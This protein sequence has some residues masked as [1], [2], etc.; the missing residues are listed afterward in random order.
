MQRE[1]Q[2]SD[3]RNIQDSYRPWNYWGWL[4]NITP[5]ETEFQI[6]EMKKAGLG[7][8]VMHARGGLEVPYMGTEWKASV[9]RMIE[10]GKELGMLSVADDEYGWPS[11]FGG[12]IVNGMGEAYWQKWLCCEETTRESLV[13]SHRTL[14]IFK[15]QEQGF[16]LCD[17]QDLPDGPLYHIY[18]D[19][20][21]YY[22]D[23]SDEKVVAAFIQA[24]Y[25]AYSQLTKEEFGRG[26]YA[27]FSDEPQISREHMQWSL[28]L[29]E[30]FEKMW[31]YPVTEHLISI[32][33]DGP[34]QSHGRSIPSE[35]LRHDFWSTVSQM[36]A[37]AYFRQIGDWCT[38]RGICFTG[39]VTY[40][41]SLYHQIT[42]NG[43][44]MPTYEYFTVPG[45]DWLGRVAVSNV[46][47]KQVTSVSA[48]LGKT[49]TLS[50]MFGCAGWN[51]SFEDMKWIAEWH[52][53]FGVNLI[54][55]HLGLYSL[56][57]SRK[58]EYPASLFYQQ[59]WW[60]QYPGWN[61]YFA[62]LSRVLSEAKEQV[63]ILLLHP[64]ETAWILTNGRNQQEI[65]AYNDRFTR[66]VDTLLSQGLDFHFGDPTILAR[67]GRIEDGRFC[68]GQRCYQT[69]ILPHMMTLSS[70]TKA[71]LEEF[72]A[73]GGRVLTVGEFPTMT[74]GRPDPSLASLKSSIPAVTLEELAALCRRP[75]AVSHAVCSGES[76]G[77]CVY[78]TV[79]SWQGA[80][81]YYLFNSSRT[82]TWEFSL[83]GEI[84]GQL[85]R[86]CLESDA[87]SPCETV[88][89][90]HLRLV[91]AQSMLL[92]DAALPAAPPA[93]RRSLSQ[94][95]LHQL[96]DFTVADSSPNS[97]V[98]DTCD[99]RI[100]PDGKWVSS[101]PV[102]TLQQRLLAEQKNCTVTMR[103]R[104]KS[105]LTQVSPLWLV[106]ENPEAC[107]IT[108]NGTP[109]SHETDQ[110]WWID[111]SF[112]KL[113]V[114]N[115]LRQG[116]N[117]ILITRRFQC[118]EETYRIK[119]DPTVHEALSNRVTVETELEAIYLLG[120]F[121]VSFTGTSQ[122]AA[123]RSTVYR[124]QYEL[125]PTPK[126]QSIEDL[127]SR[128]YPFFAGQI[129]LRTSF[130]CEKPK[131][132][133]WLT[134]APPDAVMVAVSINGKPLRTFLWGP[135]E[136]DITDWLE[137][138][139]NQ[140][141]V[142]LY[143]SC[144]NLLGPLHNRGGEPYGV[145]PYSFITN[146][147][148]DGSYCLVPFGISGGLCLWEG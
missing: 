25:E 105:Q 82:A 68:V 16:S 127:T 54:L 122:P 31:G 131:R 52:M 81:L 117:E 74:D 75:V 132:P 120:D 93:P 73:A 28:A 14:G 107:Q 51:V 2:I 22:V 21:P 3:W 15:R 30:A 86:L 96:S 55:Q 102:L 19:V 6:R 58:R 94:T 83:D 147:T 66:L 79:W 106:L 59:P 44:A 95:L 121:A 11:G 4:E 92:T 109:I 71:L 40:E 129:T 5:E 144:R 46:L 56:K 125:V 110:G 33:Y 10:V 99:Y 1:M 124:G 128:G 29:P 47:L 98:F 60:E 100:H 38:K 42:C 116:E 123:H 101:V 97:I 141:E 146:Q 134:F 65:S 113:D 50:E 67:H 108:M 119:N 145:G 88:D 118:S 17:P 87:A 36:F 140:I 84:S 57:G 143:G 37:N 104:F 27:I 85:C 23:L 32:F 91:P 112:R 69:V 80:R 13:Q 34:C 76:D 61:E 90:S 133:V 72:I 63:D 53:V 139:D 35:Q 8:Y 78:C 41:E 64:I 114:T 77:G 39:H 126:N 48:Q 137:E 135:Y 43:S 9:L 142:T 138:G 136:A 12:G 70:H 20:S 49:R 62:R 130:F 148:T 115:L 89:P 18:Y 7:G 24:S 26:L 111:K 45:V 103:F